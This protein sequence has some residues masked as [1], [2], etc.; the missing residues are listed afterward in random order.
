M[1]TG[2]I[3]AR[4]SDEGAATYLV[5]A[6]HGERG[7]F[8]DPQDYP[9]PQKLARI[10]EKELHAAAEVLGL[11]EVILL[12]YIDGELDQ[13]DPDEVIAKL[14]HQIR[15]LRPQVVVTFG[16]LGIYGH[17]DHIAISQFA[18]SA[19]LAAAD[20]GYD[21]TNGSQPHRVE[22]LYYR[23]ILQ[24]EAQAYQA[25]FGDLVMHIDGSERKVE[26]WPEWA[27]TTRV[28]TARY[29]S[30]IWQAISSHRS[31]LTGYQ[32]L[33]NLPEE[34]RNHLWGVQT[35]YRVF[36]LVNAGRELEDDLFI[37]IDK[38]ETDE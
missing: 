32:V 16:P 18:T 37:G 9:G 15:R 36:S 2:G 22:K 10:R 5:T 30:K 4:Y 12:D 34:H 13:A 23:V 26:A 33:E 31:Q 28:N 20:P 21:R 14:V 6:T 19:V 11:Q 1:G 35:F 25:A 7:W 24:G 3:L 29:A 8:G 27:V 38:G 17:P